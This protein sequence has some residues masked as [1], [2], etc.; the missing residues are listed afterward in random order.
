MIE[1]YSR[2]VSAQT[3]ASIPLNNIALLKGTSTTMQGAA[4]IQLNKS[5]IYQVNVTAS[6]TPDATAGGNISIQL[7]QN[8]VLLPQSLVTDTSA[9]DTDISAVSFTTLVQVV[10]NNNCSCFSP[11]FIDV[12]NV[13]VDAT[14]DINVT[15]TRV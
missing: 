4:S 2:S 1:V 9:S 5:G 15:V 11:S 3:N 6:G 10:P 8:N 13:G 7:R 12:V 14:F